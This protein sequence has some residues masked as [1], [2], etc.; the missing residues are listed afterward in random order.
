MTSAMCVQTG[1]VSRRATLGRAPAERPRIE[2]RTK[3]FAVRAIIPDRD[4]AKQE[5]DTCLS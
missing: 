3:R 4:G 1:K 2:S 5:G